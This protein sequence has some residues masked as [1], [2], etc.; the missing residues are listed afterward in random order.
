MR[1]YIRNYMEYAKKHP[2]DPESAKFMEEMQKY[3]DPNFFKRKRAR[4]LL[5]SRVA[6]KYM[7]RP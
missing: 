4:E 3:I 1:D 5:V 6:S 2:A 7:I